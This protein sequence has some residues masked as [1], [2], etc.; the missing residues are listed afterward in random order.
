MGRASAELPL[1]VCVGPP[2]P[3]AFQ[4]LLGTDE[5]TLIEQAITVYRERFER[6]GMFENSLFPGVIEALTAM[7]RKGH[8]MRIV[9]A[10]PQPYATKI[11][12]HF[13]IDM[14]FEAVHGP[15]LEDR[16]HDKVALVAAAVRDSGSS[17]VVMIGDRGEDIRAANVN[18]IQSIAVRW[19]YGSEAELYGRRA[20]SLCAHDG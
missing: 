20:H 5:P 16:T 18:G 4:M 19:G 17:D 11:L 3:V 1:L 2:L 14:L 9:T 10:K 8:R 12:Q 13:R 7:R 15:M 6:I